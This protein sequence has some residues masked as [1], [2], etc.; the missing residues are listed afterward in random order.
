MVLIAALLILLNLEVELLAETGDPLLQGLPSQLL[1]ELFS[2]LLLQLAAN[3]VVT[4]ER[5]GHFAQVLSSKHL[6]ESLDELGNLVREVEPAELK[7]V[8]LATVDMS[9]ALLQIFAALLQ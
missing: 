9:N 3:L 7:E 4:G 8:Y 1:F 6:K 5:S 2:F